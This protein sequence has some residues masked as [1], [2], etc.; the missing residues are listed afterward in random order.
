MFNTSA[1][2]A[3]GRALRRD[4]RVSL[5]V[6]YEQAAFAYVRS[7]G[8][9]DV[10]E[11]LAEVRRWATRIGGRYTGDD[12]AEELVDRNGV[13]ERCSCGSPPPQAVGWRG[14]AD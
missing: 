1:D 8:T 10:S 11:D 2:S 4:P 13:V 12:R 5:V 14:V 3:K 6:E 9:V 7:T